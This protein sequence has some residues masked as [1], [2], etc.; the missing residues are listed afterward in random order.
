MQC[1]SHTAGGGGGGP[2]GLNL[3]LLL[4]SPGVV[5]VHGSCGQGLAE[6][7][8]GNCVSMSIPDQRTTSPESATSGVPAHDSW[9]STGECPLGGG[10]RGRETPSMGMCSSS[11]NGGGRRETVEVW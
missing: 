5:D 11:A 4:L 1:C 6:A 10:S 9:L 7:G 2:L 3:L 8:L